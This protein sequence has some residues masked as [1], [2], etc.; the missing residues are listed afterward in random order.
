MHRLTLITAPVAKVLSLDEAKEHLRVD[1]DD[2]N[3]LIEALIAAATAWLDGWSGVLGMCLEAQTWEMSLDRFP[4]REFCIPL[5]PVA[6]IDAITY[7]DSEGSEQTLSLTEYETAGARIRP[8][9]GWPATSAKYDAVKVRFTAGNGTPENIKH[10]VRLLIAH[11]Y[12]NRESVGD[13]MEAVPMAVDMLI[14]PI[15]RVRL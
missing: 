2:E 9:S 6:S 7:I 14:A 4:A 5:G 3:T 15:R 8:V 1:H 13:K 11:W 12:E 10:V